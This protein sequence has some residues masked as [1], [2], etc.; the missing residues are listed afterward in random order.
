MK[1]P[2]ILALPLLAVFAL[3]IGGC[4]CVQ[5]IPAGHVGGYHWDAIDWE[6]APLLCL[7]CPG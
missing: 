1:R 4:T 3:L 7:D 5:T 2:I 6:G